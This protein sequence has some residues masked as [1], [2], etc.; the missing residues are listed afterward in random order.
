MAINRDKVYDGAIKLLQASKYDKAIVEFQKLIAE[1]GKDVRTL[2]K[3]AETLHVKMGKR[4]EALEHYDRAAS[5]YTEQGFFLKAVAV[6]KQMLTVDATNPDMHLKLAELYQQLGYGSQC[7]LHYQSVVQLYEQQDRGKETLAILKRMVDLDPENLQSRIKVAELFAQS[8]QMVEANAEMR[9]AFEFLKAQQRLDDAVRVGEKVL[10][11]DPNATDVARELANIYMGRNDAKQALPKL[12]MCFKLDPR[13]LEV[14]DLIAKAFLALDQ[15]P[16]TIS[17]YKEMARIYEGNNDTQQARSSWERVLQLS[18]GDD[19]AEIALGRR[20]ATVTATAVPPPAAAP[21]ATAEDEQLSRL[22]TET[23]VYVKYG[24]RDKAIEHLE[25]IFGIRPE[26]IPGLEKLKQLQTQT[27]QPAGVVET[28]KRLIARGEESNHPKLTE[29]KAELARSEKA[30]GAPAKRPPPAPPPTAPRPV[31]PRSDMSVEG[32]VILVEEEAPPPPVRPPPAAVAKSVSSAKPVVR[33][34]QPRAVDEAVD[35]PTM[36]QVRPGAMP[37]M[38]ASLPS[39]IG[40]TTPPDL[41]DEPLEPVRA[42]GPAGRPEPALR[43]TPAPGRAPAFEMASPGGDFD[44]DEPLDGGGIG[45][46][47]PDE[48][49]GDEALAD[50]LTIAPDETDFSSVAPDVPQRL[51]APRAPTGFGSKRAPPPPTQPAEVVLDD[52]DDVG[53][54]ADALV[55]EALGMPAGA[56]PADVGL[57]VAENTAGW[58][59]PMTSSGDGQPADELVLGEEDAAAAV[60]AGFDDSE[61]DALAA[62]AVQ[63]ALPRRPNAPA[64]E[65]GLSDDE[66]GELSSFVQHASQEGSAVPPPAELPPEFDGGNDEDDFGERTVAYGGEGSPSTAPVAAAG[67][68]DDDD[69]IETGERQVTPGGTPGPTRQVQPGRL[70]AAFAAAA[71]ALPR[72]AFADDAAGALSSMAQGTNEFDPNEFDLPSDVKAM[73]AN[74]SERPIAGP[75]PGAFEDFGPGSDDVTGAMPI[76]ETGQFDGAIPSLAS[77]D[78]AAIIEMGPPGSSPFA[79]APVADADD[80]GM[81]MPS[82]SRNLFQVARGFEDDPANTFFPDELAE[83]EF[84]IQ[85]DLLDEAREILTPI[86]EEVEDSLRVQH[87]LARVTAKEAGEPEPPAPWEQKLID[88]VGAQLDDMAAMSPQVESSG[89]HQVSVEDVLFQFKKGIAETVPEDDA[90]THYDLGIAYREMGLLED[91]VSEFEI[92]ARAPGKAADSFYVVGLVRVEQ[93]R[94][95]DALAA[96]ERAFFAASA[97]K[98]QRAAA[99][100]ERGVIF[101]DHKKN[102][103]EGLVCLKRSKQLGGGA[104]DLDRR[105]AALTKAHGDVEVPELAPKPPKGGNGNGG[106]N[107]GT[108][109][110]GGPAA[111]P[112]RPKNIDYV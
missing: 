79:G 91:A 60:S 82:Q 93:G 47:P 72:E 92:A 4:K 24:L 49:L 51:S 80:A 19:D 76:M 89:P 57:P 52:V 97:S 108:H 22:L 43:G 5:I 8:G 62:Q 40:S 11:W 32:E 13:N 59:P 42:R 15:T 21:R 99:E 87:M 90:A 109:K 98:D 17:V 86:L 14:L 78:A 20:S 101:A 35:A 70:D 18:P 2:L 71:D 73:L 6:F 74:K 58:P 46:L 64:A 26:Y 95:D 1:D 25:K 27:K 100:Y 12:Q 55:R 61:I 111:G 77:V 38:L 7:L 39:A 107:G 110:P 88:E 104:P 33:G 63:D 75:P 65:L 50:A 10:A 37:G 106:A 85:Q 16:K 36:L 31:P 112:G 29:W 94:P 53:A 56:D 28:L 41:D 9:S 105:I 3:I 81:D 44:G 102:G 23:D 83:A 69:N 66:L 96:L 67:T 54:D 103:R 84:F 45:D 34:G 68:V 48:A 30:L